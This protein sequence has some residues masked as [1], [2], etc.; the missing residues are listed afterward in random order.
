MPDF[1]PFAEVCL[2][3]EQPIRPGGH[4]LCRACVIAHNWSLSRFGYFPERPKAAKE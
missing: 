2:M 3:C 4:E 1:D